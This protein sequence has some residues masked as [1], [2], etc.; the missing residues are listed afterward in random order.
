V[1][2]KEQSALSQGG[3]PGGSAHFIRESP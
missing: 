1:A 2:V 3:V